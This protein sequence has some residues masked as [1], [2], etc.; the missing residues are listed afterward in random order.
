MKMI[1]FVLFFNGDF[2][3][4]HTTTMFGKVYFPSK[5]FVECNYERATRIILHEAVHLKDEKES[6]VFFKLGYLFPQILALLALLAFVNLWFLLFLLALGPWP[7]PFR[8]KSELR[9][10]EKTL[11]MI[12]FCDY[13]ISEAVTSL[14]NIFTGWGYYRMSWSKTR[15]RK[16]IEAI[17]EKIE[18]NKEEMLKVVW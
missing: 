16:K 9:G 5:D 7:A 12:I 2:M 10:F 13:N 4:G 8:E 1:G 15:I 6:P 18:R 3:N 17:V 11:L 14:A